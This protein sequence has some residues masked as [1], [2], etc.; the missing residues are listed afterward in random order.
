MTC[1]IVRSVNGKKVNYLLTILEKNKEIHINDDALQ[2]GNMDVLKFVHPVAAAFFKRLFETGTPIDKPIEFGGQT[3][4]YGD[5]SMPIT[6]IETMWPLFLAGNVDADFEDSF[7]D[8]VANDAAA[9]VAAAVSD[10][11][12]ILGLFDML[13][14]S[15]TPGDFPMFTQQE[16]ETIP[17]WESLI[18]ELSSVTIERNGNYY[19]KMNDI[20]QDLDIV[21]DN[22]TIGK[23]KAEKIAN[24][25]LEA[26]P[27][28][29]I[30]F[31]MET[32]DE[33]NTWANLEKLLGSKGFVLINK[34]R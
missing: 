8:P 33:C 24:L 30:S 1:T 26:M 11:D 5:L 7:V 13:P 27:I 34:D 3:M 14:V 6:N 28:Q 19:P 16:L 17:G 32:D 9:V 21:A 20:K 22:W 29:I 31:S 25:E 10:A 18:S 2:S 12:A 4:T 23:N 15:V